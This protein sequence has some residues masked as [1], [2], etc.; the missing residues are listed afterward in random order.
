MSLSVG[1][2][3]GTY[4]IKMVELLHKRRSFRLRRLAQLRIPSAKEKNVSENSTVEA[5]RSLFSRYKI[6]KRCVIAGIGGDSAIVRRIK[7]PL[8]KFKELR[9]AI[10]WEAEQYIPYPIDQVTLRFHILEEEPSEKEERKMSVILVGVKNEAI[11]AHLQLLQKVGI[12]PHI[13]DIN[14]IALFN[15]FN[16]SNSKEK[17]RVALVDLGHSMTNLVLLDKRG[18]FLIRTISIGGLQLTQAIAQQLNLDYTAAEKIKEEYGLAA[19][20]E[21]E[22]MKERSIAAQVDEI[23]RKSIDDLIE[24]IVRSFE[25]YASQTGGSTIKEMVLV[26]GTSYLK[27]I[28][29]FLSR[30]LGLPVRRFNPFESITYSPK[31]FSP[32]YL[33]KVGSIFAVGLG[34]ALRRRE[35]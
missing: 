14:P 34:L 7:V 24:E 21:S 16:L 27:G 4:S 2:E 30:E 26:G 9:R 35:L 29:K 1:L 6:D 17:D 19:L 15:I 33:D 3:I 8:M 13:I 25:Y 20:E 12:H 32:D 10:R 22:K 28:D 18:P 11:E 31:E 23:I 5:I